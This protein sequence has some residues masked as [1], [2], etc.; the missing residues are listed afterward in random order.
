[1]FEG[2]RNAAYFQYLPLSHWL[3][4]LLAMLSITKKKKLVKYFE[5]VQNVNTEDHE[6]LWCPGQGFNIS[7]GSKW[8]NS[9]WCR[10][11]KLDVSI[12]NQE[13][14]KGAFLRGKGGGIH[15]TTKE[16]NSGSH[17]KCSSKQRPPSRA[18]LATQNGHLT[19][20]LC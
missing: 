20:C 4:R 19:C 3:T 11:L 14:G 16:K 17:T 10:F 12:Q 8:W 9:S 5:R 7:E 2:T 6:A 15:Q 1:V 18:H 13:A